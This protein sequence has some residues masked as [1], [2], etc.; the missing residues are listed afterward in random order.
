MIGK[1]ASIYIDIGNQL[2]KI[3]SFLSFSFINNQMTGFS[4][5]SNVMLDLNTL[6]KPFSKIFIPKSLHHECQIK[7]CVK[8][9]VKI[10][11]IRALHKKISP[12][13]VVASVR[14]PTKKM[15]W[16]EVVE[17]ALG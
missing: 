9:N 6:N 15:L 8:N 12:N 4:E 5:I 3:V 1:N 14:I 13:F 2:K 11:H 10:F 7:G 17:N 16:L